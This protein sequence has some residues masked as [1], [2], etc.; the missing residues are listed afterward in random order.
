MSTN[1]SIGEYTNYLVLEWRLS[2]HK[3]E[4]HMFARRQLLAA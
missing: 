3:S 1:N 2:M 4:Y